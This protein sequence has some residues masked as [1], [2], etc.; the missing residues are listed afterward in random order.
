MFLIEASSYRY[1]YGALQNL[2][3]SEPDCEN[4]EA[5]LRQL[6]KK[7]PIRQDAINFSLHSFAKSWDI[8]TTQFFVNDYNRDDLLKMATLLSTFSEHIIM[9]GI[10]ECDAGKPLSYLTKILERMR[11]ETVP[12]MRREELYRM[13]VN[14]STPPVVPDFR[15][16]GFITRSIAEEQFFRAIQ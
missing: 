16:P 14:M 3:S 10:T 11:A 12:I 15:N 9:R 13:R 5:M 1:S 4:V 8:F 7:P 2:I 6:E